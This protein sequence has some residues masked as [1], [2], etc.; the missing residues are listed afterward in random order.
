[1]PIRNA[2]WLPGGSARTP[3]SGGDRPTPSRLCGSV[4][5]A[6][7]LALHRDCTL[8]E[9]RSREPTVRRASSLLRS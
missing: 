2:L 4:R 6:G 5:E 8:I 7:K 3:L 1:M 9:F